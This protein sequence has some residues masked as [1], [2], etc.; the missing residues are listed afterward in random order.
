MVVGRSEPSGVRS[1]GL[2]AGLRPEPGNDSKLPCQRGFR[3]IRRPRQWDGFGQ[4]QAACGRALNALSA[5]VPDREKT[6]RSEQP[7]R[8]G[9]EHQ[10]NGQCQQKDAEAELAKDEEEPEVDILTRK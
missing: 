5:T 6:A 4:Q 1:S 10:R 2:S 8:D 3:Q 7:Q 9:E